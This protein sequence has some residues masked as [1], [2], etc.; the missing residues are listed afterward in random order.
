MDFTLKKV[1]RVVF[2]ILI[3]LAIERIVSFCA[4]FLY[5]WVNFDK[6]MVWTQE[7]KNQ[8]NLSLY[9]MQNKNIILLTGIIAVI[10]IVIFYNMLK[11]EWNKRPYCLELFPS[12]KKSYVYVTFIAIGFTISVNLLI[13]AWGLFKYDWD[14]AQVSRMIYYEPIYMQILVIGIL[15]PICEELLFRGLI[16]ERILYS[17]RVFGN[18]TPPRH[19]GERK[20][21]L[22]YSI[23]RRLGDGYVRVFLR[24]ALRTRRQAQAYR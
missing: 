6:D 19:C 24:Y 21:R 23:H 17:H 18:N 5:I 8:V 11:K 4:N 14:F 10:G 13:N 15:V 16:Y 2:P 1:F 12:Y 3:Y 20:I 7:V 22:S 9:D